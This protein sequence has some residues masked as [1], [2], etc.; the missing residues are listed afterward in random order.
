MAKFR[1][2]NVEQF[3]SLTNLLSLRNGGQLGPGNMNRDEGIELDED[4]GRGNSDTGDSKEDELKQRFLDRF[5]EIM[6]RDKG[7]KHVCCVAMQE[8]GDRHLDEDVNVSL[9]LARN[10]TFTEQDTKFC[11]ILGGLLAAIGASVYKETIGMR[12]GVLRERPSTDDMCIVGL[13]VIERELWEELLCYNQPRL[14]LYADSL[15]DNLK[16]FKAAGSLDSIPPYRASHSPQTSDP[17]LKTFC[18]CTSIGPYSDAT[19]DAYMKLAQEHVRRLDSI[20]CTGD[21]ATQRRL[22][23]EH[24]HSIRHLESL[25]IYI[26]SCPKA[27]VGRRLL[28]DILFLGRL[29]SCYYTLVEAALN[30]PGFA[31]LSIVLVKNLPPRVCPATLPSLADAMKYLGQALNPSS[32]KR[33]ISAKASVISAERNFKQIQNNT[34]RKHLHTHAEL[35]LILHIT[36]TA[37][38]RTVNGEIYPYIGCSKLSCFLCTAFLESFKYGGVTFRTR[39]SHGKIYTLWSIPDM[40]GLREDLVTT[41]HSA[42]KKTRNLLVRE[43]IKPIMIAAHTSESTAGVTDYSPQSSFVNRYHK[44]LAAQREFDSLSANVPKHM[45]GK[46][47]PVEELENR[48]IPGTSERTKTPE[49]CGECDNCER[50]TTRKCSRCRGP[51]L[52]S[53]RCENE[54]DYHGHTFK[55]AIGRP[56]D[57]ADYLV[58]ACWTDFLDDLDEDTKEDFGFAKFASVYDVQKLFGLYVGLTRMGVRSR[59]LHK[60]QIEGTLTENI[61]AKYEAI[62]EHHRGGYYPWFRKNLHVFN[63][64]SGPPDF[65]AVARPYLDSVDR[66][67]EPHQLVPEAKRKS[68]ILYAMLLNGY[69]P[70]PSIQSDTICKELYFEFGFVT[71]CGS[72]GE[73]VLPWVYRSLIPKCSFTEFWTAFQSNTLVALMDAK[74][75]GPMCREVRHLEAFMK[76]G[77]NH[78]C[79]TVWHLR[80]FINSPDVDPPRYVTV[81]YGFFNCKTVE[82]KFSLKGVYKELLGSSRVDPMELHAACIKGKLYDF[83]RGHIPNLERRFK[84]LMTT[85]YPLPTDVEWAGMCAERVAIHGLTAEVAQSLISTLGQQNVHIVH[86]EK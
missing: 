64:P 57:T 28:S 17:E 86:A 61:T 31:R 10:D 25:R 69:H 65:L 83:V 59:E 58:R 26:D 8:S 63:S 54:W 50:E 18:D 22:L 4:F 33:F 27:S 78:W 30:I 35:Q 51:W 80:L 45:V 76:I 14:G 53:E 39:G 6:S 82:E 48:D 79:P 60:W 81:D 21:R 56:L 41:L 62:P 67:K 5:A 44:T 19:H 9:L 2:D 42:L 16:A 46:F 12:V 71:G 49:L 68:F 24:T 36:K 29:R 40:D 34:S 37:D 20:L 85:T 73:Q 23:A 66:E 7:G 47:D 74:G 38:V 13:P 52:C 77:L 43:M 3:I 32:V 55:C 11:D 70:N 84:R 72:E 1:W 75:L 15:H